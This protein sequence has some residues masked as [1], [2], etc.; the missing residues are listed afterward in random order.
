[1]E[2]LAHEIAHAHETVA[3]AEAS[4]AER[5]QQLE[6]LAGDRDDEAERLGHELA[7]ARERLATAEASVNERDRLIEELR[8][9]LEQ[10]TVDDR[11][12]TRNPSGSPER[13]PT[14]T[15]AGD[16]TSRRRGPRAAGA[17]A[18]A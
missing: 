16:R 12:R 18:P 5:D 7:H 13:T 8:Q 11:S 14:S 3:A 1:M 15:C 10:V 2:R 4:I 6:E 17:G 9:K